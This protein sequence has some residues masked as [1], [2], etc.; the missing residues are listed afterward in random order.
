MSMSMSSWGIW[1]LLVDILCVMYLL[2][3][4]MVSLVVWCG[5]GTAEMMSHQYG[6]SAVRSRN[7]VVGAV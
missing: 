2:N 6:L 3:L 7:T 5:F 4:Q 1:A